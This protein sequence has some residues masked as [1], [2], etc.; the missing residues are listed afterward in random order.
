MNEQRKLKAQD[1]KH[2]IVWNWPEPQE[3]RS[4]EIIDIITAV[5][6]ELWEP[7]SIVKNY[8]VHSLQSNLTDEEK[9][10]IDALDTT[11]AL[12]ILE[13]EN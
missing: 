6:R 12:E 13:M 5:K 9:A 11:D 7:T 4:S 2:K 8:N 10:L 1:P 3:I